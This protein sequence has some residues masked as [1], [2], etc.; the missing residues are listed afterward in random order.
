MLCL[1]GVRRASPPHT[2][3]DCKAGD[4]KGTDGQHFQQGLWQAARF[5]PVTRQLVNGKISLFQPQT[6]EGG[7]RAAIRAALIGRQ[8]FQ[9]KVWRLDPAR[10]LKF[11]IVIAEIQAWSVTNQ[12]QD[13]VM[14]GLATVPLFSHSIG[15][16][17][18]EWTGDFTDPVVLRLQADLFKYF[19][20]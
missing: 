18:T 16:A 7:Q 4:G 8:P 19:A 20:L 6:K 11:R 14:M 17:V 15:Q 1:I 3:E 13:V 5:V 2:P 9:A 10:I 12:P